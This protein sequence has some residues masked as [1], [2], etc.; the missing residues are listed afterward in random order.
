LRE[1]AQRHVSTIYLKFVYYPVP[2]QGQY[3]LR[4]V[5]HNAKVLCVSA[6]ILP[7][8]I[9]ILSAP[10]GKAAIDARTKMHATGQVYPHSGRQAEDGS[11]GS[12][13]AA[14]RPLSIFASGGERP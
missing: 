13:L 4:F 12:K 1:K 8:Q 5:E 11:R 3:L 9:Q 6:R 2:L 7:V 10:V 14:Q